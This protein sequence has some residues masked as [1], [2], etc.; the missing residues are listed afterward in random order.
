MSTIDARVVFITTSPRTAEKMIPEIDLLNQ[1]FA[2]QVWNKET[3]CAF[4]DVLRN[5]NFFNGKGEKDPSFSARDRINR[6]PKAYGFVK[7]LPT[8]QLTPAG[9][10]LIISKRKQEVFFR[11]LLK[12]QLPSPY[13][14]LSANGADFCVKPFLEIF[15][16]IRHFGTLK[17]DELQ[18]FGLQLTNYNRF[19]EIV[20][21]IEQYRI[22]KETTELQYS[23]FR[24][25]VQEDEIKKIYR[26]EIKS[27]HIK[28][29]EKKGKNLTKF[30]NTKNS[31]MRDY[32]DACVR[33]LRATGM[34]NVSHVG[35]T[36]SIVPEHIEDVDYAL[37][38]VGRE[39]VFVDDET[40]YSEY[41]GS[42]S[43][44]KLLTDNKDLLVSKIRR[45]FAS[46]VIDVNK[47]IDELRDLLDDLILDRQQKLIEKTVDELK[48][49]KQYDEI[50]SQYNRILTERSLYD[51]PLLLEWN[52]WRALS[53]LD[54][55]EIKANLKFDDFGKPM[56]TAQGN[57]S[58]I[59]CDYGEFGVSVEVTMSSGQ[60]QYEMEGESVTRHLGKFKKAINKP[61]FCLFIAPCINP[62][63][64]GHFYV[65]HKLNIEVYGGKSNIVPLPLHIFMKMV[66]DSYKAEYVP[67]PSHVKRFFDV[68]S[69]LA[70]TS[71]SEKEWYDGV[72]NSAL[73]WL[74]L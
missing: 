8:I 57:M 58:D 32:A 49:Y 21:K 20:T 5:E 18:I 43:Q 4:M 15:R 24:K 64:I 48:D 19:D 60:R 1:H 67:G 33:Y 44:P 2:G 47:S 17:F 55:G 35:R 71:K 68:A 65:L 53:M 9:E 29:R 61:A 46:V 54:G 25:Q 28:T 73:N 56:S 16:L 37:N 10:K 38:N 22:A 23:A 63:V 30:I 31:N 45:E 6:A 69:D 36:L 62:T 74:K 70:E 39:P 7:L 52:T 40:R 27:N 50:Q 3:Q 51:A 41:L 11:Q 66:E 42:V 34:V 72:I 14:E 12:F 59:V 26:A 13:H